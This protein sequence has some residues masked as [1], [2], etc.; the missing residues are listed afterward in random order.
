MLISETRRLSPDAPPLY[1]EMTRPAEARTS[2]LLTP[3]AG[4][5]SGVGGRFWCDVAAPGGAVVSGW[6]DFPEGADARESY[7]RVLAL[8]PDETDPV[9]LWF[10]RPSSEV[11]LQELNMRI[12]GEDEKPLAKGAWAL[13][14]G[15]HGGRL[16]SLDLGRSRGHATV[17]VEL[18]WGEGPPLFVQVRTCDHLRAE[19][20][21]TD[22]GP[23]PSWRVIPDLDLATAY[24]SF[25]RHGQFHAA[26]AVAKALL[27]DVE[28]SGG[29]DPRA[30]DLADAAVTV[31]HAAVKLRSLGREFR[32]RAAA[33]VE[34]FGTVS[35][36][37]RAIVWAIGFDDA[38]R[39]PTALGEGLRDLALGLMSE[40]PYHTEVLRVLFE[41]LGTAARLL[42]EAGAAD[43]D[44]EAAV[45]AVTELAKATM[46]ERDTLAYRATRPAQPTPATNWS[47]NVARDAAQKKTSS[48]SFGQP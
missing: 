37:L 41:R 5:T 9:D 39:R 38:A 4:R 18:D 34:P 28:A 44:V 21:G 7:A 19:V 33:A 2:D 17:A 1:V 45:G 14:P 13:S 3:G 47:E 10:D 24:W 23:I 11:E 8:F 29:R 30:A 22:L 12:W 27:M 6:C 25:L 42:A 40:R 32:Q 16:F 35:L 36:D 15:A 43:P 31:G 48:A 26:Q 46:W 20:E